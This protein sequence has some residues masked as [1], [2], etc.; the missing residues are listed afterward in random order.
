MIDRLRAVQERGWLK[1]VRPGNSGG[2]GNTIDGLL[3]LS[4]NNLPIADTAQWEMKTH[5][6]GSASLLTLFHM[7]PE[8]RA[9]Q[10]VAKV[11]LP[12]Y[13]WPDQKG[14]LNELSFRQTLRTT[15]ASDRGFR[16]QLDRDA[17]RLRVTFDATLTDTARHP[18]WLG[19]VMVRAGLGP[20]DPEPY[21]DLRD[22]YL[23]AST[24]MLNA[25]YVEVLT[26][27]D[28]GDEDFLINRVLT[29]QGFDLDRFAD[30][31]D[32]GGVLVDFD[33]RTRHNHGTKIR[34]KQDLVPNLY[35]YV[36]LVL[37]PSGATH[38][39]GL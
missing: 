12:K 19:S 2:I 23:K 9:A 8:P 7:E 38:L 20:L 11:L 4:E 5:R 36:D 25:F 21:W 13:G 22:L 15:Q 34:L 26:R 30:T 27:R 10:V 24:K 29:L 39:T 32:A 3:G 37:E 31:I 14:R 16:I 35:R 28:G 6:A 17:E 1:S 18:E 33:A